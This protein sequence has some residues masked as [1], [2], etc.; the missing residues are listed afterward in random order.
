MLTIES[1]REFAKKLQT[2][3]KNVVRE[4]IQHLCLSS[5]YKNKEAQNL[6]FKGGTALRLI[7]QSPR[8]SEDLDFTGHFYHRKGIEELLLESLV[9]VERTGIS[10][11]LK[12]AKRTTGGYLAIIHYRVFDFTEDINVEISLR[13]PKKDGNEVVTII[14]EIA[15]PYT[16][17]CL[18]PRVLVREKMHALMQRK[19]PRDYYDVYFL[20][21][22]PAL[23]KFV[24]KKMLDKILLQ[25]EK[26]RIDFKKEL[27]PFLPV[28]HHTILR[29]FKTTLKEE[30]SQYL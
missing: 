14:S 20:L 4:Y 9:E 16:L 10:I 30:V 22:H 6:L 7:Y 24:D 5:L 28:S 13:K 15:V 3:E 18:S 25:I 29:N 17:Y 11:H 19:K 23:N 26:E 27:S 12:E 21:R 8:F 1:L 2:N